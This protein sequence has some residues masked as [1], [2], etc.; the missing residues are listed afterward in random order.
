M[1]LEKQFEQEMIDIYTAA[2]KECGYHAVVSSGVMTLGDTNTGLHE[3]SPFTSISAA[4]EVF[5][6]NR[7]NGQFSTFYARLMEWIIGFPL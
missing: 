6:E 3:T 7:L 5:A 2:K 1:T 4:I